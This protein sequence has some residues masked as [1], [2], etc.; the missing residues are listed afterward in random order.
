[1]DL[2]E[3]YCELPDELKEELR[4]GLKDCETKW[5][6]DYHTYDERLY[7]A[8]LATDRIVGIIERKAE[9]LCELA[10]EAGL[11]EDAEPFASVLGIFAEL[12]AEVKGEE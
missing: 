12:L 1:M 8:E 11:P 2:T 6:V 10:E 3:Q 7:G 9:K 5:D 4:D